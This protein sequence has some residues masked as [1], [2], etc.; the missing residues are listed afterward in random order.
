M[1][2]QLIEKDI[3]KDYWQSEKGLHGHNPR[4]AGGTPSSLGLVAQAVGT[5]PQAR[6]SI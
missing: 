4:T 5:T 3:Y 6:A 2:L 1:Y